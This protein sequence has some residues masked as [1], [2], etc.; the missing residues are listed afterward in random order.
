LPVPFKTGKDAARPSRKGTICRLGRAAGFFIVGLTPPPVE[1]C[2][3]RE[4]FDK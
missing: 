3:P 4:D 1:I 2:L